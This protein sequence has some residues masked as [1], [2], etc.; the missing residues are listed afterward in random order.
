[1]KKKYKEEMMR[2]YSK[3][4]AKG[5]GNNTPPP[6]PAPVMPKAKTESLPPVM[7]K[8]EDML[9]VMPEKDK[10]DF[11]AAK[12]P[13]SKAHASK[14]HASSDNGSRSRTPRFPD[15]DEILK[16]ENAAVRANVNMNGFAGTGE[17]NAAG[18]GINRSDGR[19]SS[20]NHYQGN[21]D[22]NPNE[23]NPPANDLEPLYDG[24]PP[25]KEKN[26][27]GIGYIKAEVTTGSG[28]APVEGATVII[29]KKKGDK[30]ML[31]KM[32]VTDENGETEEVELPAPDISYSESPDPAER[33]FSEYRISVSADGYYTVPEIIVPVF[34]TVKSIQPV[35]MIPLA[36]FDRQGSVNPAGDNSVKGR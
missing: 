23:E 16:S 29:T 25:E 30:T 11:S 26:L 34:S 13:A 14:A 1:M 15:P 10:K 20:E 19:N 12:T 8:T 24:Y 21:Y 7:P 35:A 6:A 28:S 36:E 17:R 27:T 33:P 2:L 18:S 5:S 22:F 9:P 32:L 3:S 4:S 31:I